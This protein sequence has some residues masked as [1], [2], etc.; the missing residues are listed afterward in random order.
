MEK[1]NIAPKVQ[2]TV[3]KTSAPIIVDLGSASRKAI[4]KL[5]EGTGKLMLEVDQAVEHARSRLSEDDRQKHILPIVVIY[6]KKRR[7]SSSSLP[8]SSLNPLNMLR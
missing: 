8:F 3:V 4:K 5:R 1:E 2:V 6:R 7:K